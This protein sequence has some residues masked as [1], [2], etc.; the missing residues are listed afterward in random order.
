MFE[1]QLARFPQNQGERFKR[2]PG[3]ALLE[4]F[5]R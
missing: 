4:A 5:L 3:I 1:Q 2:S